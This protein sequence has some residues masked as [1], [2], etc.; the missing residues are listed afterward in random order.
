MIDGVIVT[1]QRIIDVPGGD[2]LHIV[3][4]GDE[5]FVGF[6]EAYFS[7]IE[8]GVVKAWKKHNKMALNLVVPIGEVRFVLFDDRDHS[9]SKDTFF[10]ISL[11]NS[12]YCR[13][14]VPAGIWFGFQGMSED[15]SMLINIA[16]IPHDPDEVDRK[17]VNK[18]EYKW[19]NP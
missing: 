9:S 3:K 14:T 16:S 12:N 8:Y 13:L 2:V 19:E 5:G 7:T 11:S 10:E 17:A 1:P 4:A 15:K 6:G 18:I